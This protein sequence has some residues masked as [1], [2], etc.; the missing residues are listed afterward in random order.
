[1]VYFPHDV[2]T[3]HF[4]SNRS[5][6]AFSSLNTALQMYLLEGGKHNPIDFSQP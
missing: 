2:G 4:I 6:H 5:H 3:T 1:M